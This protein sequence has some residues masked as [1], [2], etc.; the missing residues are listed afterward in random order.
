MKVGPGFFQI[1]IYIS[2]FF[3][4]LCDVIIQHVDITCNDRIR[5]NTIFIFLSPYNILI[6]GLLIVLCVY[7]FLYS[8]K[9]FFPL[10]LYKTYGRYTD[11][12]VHLVNHVWLYSETLSLCPSIHSHFSFFWIWVTTVVLSVSLSH[13]WFHSMSQL[14]GAFPSVSLS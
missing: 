8:P 3:T 12:M 2:Y 1:L 14:M 13:Q 10:A 6:V 9:S 7:V 11:F 5:V 4:Y